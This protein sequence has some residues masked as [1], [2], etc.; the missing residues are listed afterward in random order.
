MRYALGLL[1]SLTVVTAGPAVNATESS[2]S[3]LGCMTCLD[4]YT[5]NRHCDDVIGAWRNY[6][7][8]GHWCN[9]GY[10]YN[11]CSSN[12]SAYGDGGE[13]GARTPLSPTDEQ[14]ASLLR[15]NPSAS[16]NSQSS[17]LRGW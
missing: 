10:Y 3:T 12:H 13:E 2:H 4:D 16:L 17:G 14:I 8:E 7:G 1:L 6:Q 9:S 11:T 5:R 15:E